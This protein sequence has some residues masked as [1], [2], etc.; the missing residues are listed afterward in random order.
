MKAP[1]TPQTA[2]EIGLYRV[3]ELQTL[4]GVKKVKEPVILSAPRLT[5]HMVSDMLVCELGGYHEP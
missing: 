3:S 1:S 2:R 5:I 4:T